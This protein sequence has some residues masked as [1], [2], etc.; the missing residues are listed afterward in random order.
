MDKD[1]ADLF[2]RFCPL[3][4]LT[5][6]GLAPIVH[7]LEKVTSIAGIRLAFSDFIHLDSLGLIRFGGV[8]GFRIPFFNTP[9]LECS[10][11]GRKHVFAKQGVRDLDIGPAFLTEVGEELAVIA[12]SSPNEDYR[13]DLV[14]T[15]RQSGWEVTEDDPAPG[16]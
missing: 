6:D 1:D 12:G 9:T 11:G 15:L 13:K 8:G 5:P 4:W 10:Y 2:T 7:N 16:N 3:I 14:S